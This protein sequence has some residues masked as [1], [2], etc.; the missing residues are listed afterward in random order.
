MEAW[1]FSALELHYLR[2]F[3]IHIFR[4]KGSDSSFSSLVSKKFPWL[5]SSC[6]PKQC[7]F[8]MPPAAQT[9]SLMA[10][11]HNGLL[12]Q[13]H[14]RGTVGSIS[15]GPGRC[16]LS[17]QMLRVSGQSGM[18]SPSDTGSHPRAFFNTFTFQCVCDRRGFINKVQC[19]A[20]DPFWLGQMEE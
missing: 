1:P 12:F 7:P 3:C 18:P 11:W 4:K 10:F 20:K 19:Q 5:K 13:G 17:G 2:I 6:T 9:H 8:Q 14:S 16:W 15:L